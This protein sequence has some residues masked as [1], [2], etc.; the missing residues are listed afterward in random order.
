MATPANP[1]NSITQASLI[2]QGFAGRALQFIH[3]KD[4][5]REIFKDIIYSIRDNEI[6]SANP[7]GEEIEVI[8]F[9]DMVFLINQNIDQQ[10]T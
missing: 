6:A 4:S 3:L 2:I 1:T 8:K 5:C 7:K 9:D 10:L